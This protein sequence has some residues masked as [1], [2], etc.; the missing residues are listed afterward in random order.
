[1]YNAI[2]GRKQKRGVRRQF[3]LLLVLALMLQMVGAAPALAEPETSA[4]V[5]TI[6]VE[7]PESEKDLFNLFQAVKQVILNL[8]SND[9]DSQSLY[10]GA[11]K[12]L[13]ESLGD[14]YSQYLDKDQFASLSSSLEGEFSGIGVTIDLIDGSITVVNTFKNSPAEKAGIK[15]GDIIIGADD[16]DLRG[17]VPHDASL[18]LRGEAGTDV[19][20]SI[21][22]PSTGEVLTLTIT[23]AV[24]TIPSMD[25]K[26]LGDGVYY[27]EISQFTS[28]TGKT[29]SAIMNHI[30]EQGATGIILDLRNNPGGLLD[31]SVEVA[32]ELVPRGPVVELRRKDLSEVLESYKDTVPMPT[33][34]L[35]NRGTAS[36]A[37]IVA[38]AVRDRAAGIIIGEPTFGKGC[39]QTVIPIGGELGGF[40]LTIAD[41]YTPAGNLLSGTGLAPDILLQPEAV[42]LPEEIVYKRPLGQGLIGLDVL[43]LQESLKFLGYE[44]GALDGVFGPKTNAAVAAFCRD[45]KLAYSG[46][47][48]EGQVNRLNLA[49]VE[50]AANAPD[51]VLD[52]AAATLRKWL[53]T[54]SWK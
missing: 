31:A 48:T 47:I 39:V 23:R 38:G 2:T 40:R 11:I 8:H 50:R 49:V 17:K 22:R 4:E 32:G 9:V 13:F 15:A 35:V 7:I 12:G 45:Q 27:I 52:K 46:I 25:F 37:E 42:Q 26:D 1:M 36:A 10:Q 21:K 51:T 5:P 28:S 6:T 53:D 16:T 30:R 44:V 34:V 18:V 20:V 24:I 41:Y 19:R 14:P 43:A 29:F 54:G 3:L 33:V